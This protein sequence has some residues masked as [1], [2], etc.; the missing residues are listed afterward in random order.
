[1]AEAAI[2][3]G[4]ERVALAVEQVRDRLQRTTAALTS[5]GVPYAVI[6]GNAVAEWVGR[7][8]P[9]AVRNT[10]DVDILLRR[11]D[12]DAAKAAMEA[13]GFVYRHAASID[14]F[15]DGPGAKAR[16]AVHVL[17]A[18]EKVRDDYALP[19]PDVTESEPGGTFRVLALEALVRMKL[20]SNRRKDQVHLQ[21]FLDVGLIDAS[22]PARFPP[23][24][25][26]RLQHL[27]D[28]PDG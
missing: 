20:T 9:A 16:D 22:W 28:T 12:F 25:A 3:S 23:E 14:M 11:A 24:L 19:T 4:W 18:N 7:T 15:L 8:D 17:F 2:I 1:M 6:G 27:I 5:A 13:A 21:D 26:A 10:Q